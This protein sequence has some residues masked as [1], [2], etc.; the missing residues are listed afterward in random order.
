ML[1][2]SS[3]VEV[4]VQKHDFVKGADWALST[5]VLGAEVHVEIMSI[6]SGAKIHLYTVACLS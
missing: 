1:M 6:V 5:C 4:Q 2:C 3:L